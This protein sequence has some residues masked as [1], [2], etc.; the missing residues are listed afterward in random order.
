M[1]SLTFAKEAAKEPVKE[2][3]ET[4]KKGEYRGAKTAIHPNWFKESFLDL[5]DDIAD[6]KANNKRLVLY[7]WQSG[8]PYCNQLWEDN[9]S[10]QVIEDQF[11][12]NFE[13]IAINMWG[14]RDVVS[15]AG[16]TYTE[17][18]FSEAL[19]IQYTPT[20]LFFDEN[21]K[22][23]HRLNGYIP[24]R[25]FKLS[26]AYVS[27]KQ[28]KIQTFG[29][30]SLHQKDTKNSEEQHAEK[31]HSEDFFSQADLNLGSSQQQQVKQKYLAVFFEAT[32]CRDCDLL[33]EKSLKNPVK[34]K[35]YDCWLIKNHYSL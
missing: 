22:V 4:I 9:F 21:K 1:P 7:F 28:E 12:E 25:D 31:L 3:V 13:V 6:A 19:A 23:V 17:K 18:S 2:T 27:G 16:K 15:I 29:E 24:P 11:R 10:Q 34:L 26:L 20:L 35:L 14:D 5:D 30:F 32:N 8:C 33:H